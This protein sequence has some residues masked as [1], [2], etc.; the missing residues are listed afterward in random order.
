MGLIVLTIALACRLIEV[1]DTAAPPPPPEATTPP[2][3]PPTQGHD[4]PDPLPS[5]EVI[6]IQSPG[7]GSQV[8]SPVTVEGFSG[9][10]FEQT[11]AVT[12]TDID[13]TMLTMQPTTIQADLGQAGPFSL[14]LDFVVAADGPGRISVYD[15]SARDGG[16]VHLDSV[17]VTLLSTGVSEIVPAEPADE[18]IQIY[19]PT[20][21]EEVSGSVLEVSGYSEYFFEGNLSV[22]ICGSWTGGGPH[23]VCG[24]N[25]NVIAESYA[26]IQS[27]DIGV[28]GP[29]TGTIPYLVVPETRARVVVFA[30]S[31]MDGGIEHLSSVEVVLNP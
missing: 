2:Q 13:G 12:V 23:P 16:I 25:D 21:L 4:L 31:P 24:T 26:T 11:L 5:Q 17:P 14:T 28:P 29:F 10:T 9:P 22:T 6:F 7:L 1:A 27:P 15:V 19:S 20:F 30:V 8:V 18:T 3:P